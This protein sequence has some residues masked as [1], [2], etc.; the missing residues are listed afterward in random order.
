MHICIDM[1]GTIADLY[2]FPDWL[3]ALTQDENPDP[4][5][6]CAPLVDCRRLRNALNCAMDAGHDVYIISWN[7]GGDPSRAYR[8]RVVSAKRRWLQAHGI[9][10]TRLRVVPN[11]KPKSSIIDGPG[12]LFDDEKRNRDEWEAS[13]AGVAYAPDD[14][15]RCIMQI[16]TSAV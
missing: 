4:Y 6:Y 8:K 2:G 5:R 9:P 1:D 11:G 7:C 10:Y 15:I 12:I 3:G 14:M 13:G 16:A